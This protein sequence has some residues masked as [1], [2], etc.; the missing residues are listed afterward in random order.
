MFQATT[1]SGSYHAKYQ[2]HMTLPIPRPTV[3][4]LLTL[5]IFHGISLSRRQLRFSNTLAEYTNCIRNSQNWM[6]CW[7][8]ICTCPLQ[9]SWTNAD[10]QLDCC[11]T[12]GVR[13]VTNMSLWRNKTDFPQSLTKREI[14]QPKPP[15]KTQPPFTAT[16]WI[17]SCWCFLDR[18]NSKS[19]NRFSNVRL[20]ST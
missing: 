3:L 14:S 10:W 2:V 20:N 17:T 8:R 7:F 4:H 9:L 18:K 1:P 6:L 11:L 15:I 5:E 12:F 13:L 19:E 16:F